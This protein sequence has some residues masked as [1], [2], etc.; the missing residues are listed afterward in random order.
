MEIMVIS[1]LMSKILRKFQII[2][3]I[4]IK[5]NSETTKFKEFK[6]EIFLVN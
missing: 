1:N 4:F 5:S 6:K 3:S 2:L